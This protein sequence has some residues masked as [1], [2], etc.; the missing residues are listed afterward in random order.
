MHADHRSRLERIVGE[1]GVDRAQAEHVL[2]TRDRERANYG[3][4]YTHQ[5][6][7][8]LGNYDLTIDSSRFGS[9]GAADLIVAAVQASAAARLPVAQASR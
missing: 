6:W 7:G 2:E 4:H 8:M 5:K 9:E 3:A 1:Y